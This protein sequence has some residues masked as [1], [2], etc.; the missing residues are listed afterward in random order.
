MAINTLKCDEASLSQTIAIFFHLIRLNSHFS[1]IFIMYYR[2]YLPRL[3]RAHLNES[4][5]KC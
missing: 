1:G 4:S 5:S 3:S 2:V